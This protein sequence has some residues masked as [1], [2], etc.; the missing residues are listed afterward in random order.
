MHYRQIGEA[1]DVIFGL[2]YSPDEQFDTQLL[3]KIKEYKK[4]K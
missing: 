2:G 4:K 1:L 3:V